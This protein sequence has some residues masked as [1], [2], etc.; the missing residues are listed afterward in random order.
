[1]KPTLD[2]FLLWAAVHGHWEIARFFKHYTDY[3][4]SMENKK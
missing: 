3:L 4:K 1:M 2:G